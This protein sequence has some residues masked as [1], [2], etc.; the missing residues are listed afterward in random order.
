M[1][2]L[3][4]YPP[5]GIPIITTYEHSDNT[6]TLVK[7]LYS[8]RELEASTHASLGFLPL[9]K[10]LN[11]F[12]NP[13]LTRQQQQLHHTQW[14]TQHQAP[15]PARE[16]ILPVIEITG[17]TACSGKT[18][19]LYHL[20]S[21]A[22][23]PAEYNGQS[24]L[25]KGHAVVLLDLSSKFSILCLYYVMQNLVSSSCSIIPSTLGEQQEAALI[26][27]SLTHLHIFRPQS[28]SSVLATLSAVS[29]YLLAQPSAHFSTN[30][31]LGLLALNDLSSFLWQDRL[32]A[33]EE[34]GIPTKMYAEKANNSVLLQRYRTLVSILRDI[35]HRFSCTIAA[36]NW[37]LSL[38]TSKG[39][40]RALRP[41]LPSVWNNFCTVN[42]V[43]ERDRIKKFGS[44]MSVEEALK[45]GSQRWEAV[46]RSGFFGWVN[47]WGSEGWKEEV[48]EGVK[49]LEMEGCFPFRVIE[50]GLEFGDDEN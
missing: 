34:A 1:W 29:T 24:T 31:P 23:L 19:I 21:L 32:D 4:S 11:I 13:P 45:E 27:D 48:R 15:S 26:T 47:W 22:L 3:R 44:G 42:V 30:R 5:E 36:T 17:A 39:G 37:G 50:K 9:D 25:G 10:L 49:G 16:K 12:Q 35:Q 7:L 40:H 41:S 33:D 6:N 14:S 18:Q 28:S 20:V 8:L 46:E 38:A 43:V 2:N